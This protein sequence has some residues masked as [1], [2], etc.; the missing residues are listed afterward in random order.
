MYYS[1]ARKTAKISLFFLHIVYVGSKQKKEEEKTLKKKY[2]INLHIL[3]ACNFRCLQ[4]FSK[5]GTEKLLPVTD[6]MKIVDNCLAGAD[7]SEFN[8]AGGE[9]MLYPGL[10]E[11]AKYIRSKGVKV[12]LITNGSLMD[13]SW[14]KNYAGLYETIGFSVDSINDET[15]RKI[16]RCDRNGNTILAGRIVE[17]C[18][19]IRRYAPECRIKINT[20]VSALNKDAVMCDFIDEIAADR[21]KILRMKPFQYGSF[22]N[23]DIQVSNE[24]FEEFVERNREKNKEKMEKQEE[25]EAGKEVRAGAEAGM[26][27]AR[28]KIVVEPDMKASY[29][30]IDS[31]GC[32][33]D[34]AVDEMTP[35]AVCDCLREDFADGLRRLTL[36]RERYEA[37]YSDSLS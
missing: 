1:N 29:V 9:P 36:D 24:E 18:G 8:I 34:N 33:L 28:R 27:T 17:L 7:V 31:N 26:E 25:K 32:L 16:G 37:R 5:F 35:V 15:N 11:L 10:V 4:C 3:E 19:L 30:L 23:L 14:I 2:K 20:V 6:W 12:S 13:E 22:S 21:W